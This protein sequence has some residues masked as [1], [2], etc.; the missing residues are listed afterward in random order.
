DE[1]GLGPGVGA[2]RN[3]PLAPGSGDDVFLAALEQLCE[4]VG[5]FDPAS[6][7]VSLGVDSGASDPESPL[8]VSNDGFRRVGEKIE[9]LDLPTTLVQEGGYDL[10]A[11]GPDVMAVLAAFL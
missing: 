9:A 5:D 8:Q 2:N 11:L 10:T 7:V 4:V 1:T 3:L 6:L